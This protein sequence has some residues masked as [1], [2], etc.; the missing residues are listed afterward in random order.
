MALTKGYV[1][2]VA[3]LEGWWT[4]DFQNVVSVSPILD[5]LE[6]TTGI[7]SVILRSSTFH[8]LK[9]N[10]EVYKRIRGTGILYW[11]FHGVKGSIRLGGLKG[12]MIISLDE[13]ANLM[14]KRF[15]GWVCLFA[16][17]RLLNVDEQVILDFIS[18]TQVLMVVGYTV[19]AN[20][21]ESCCLEILLLD[22]LQRFKDMKK[23]MKSFIGEYKDLV[24]HTGMIVRHRP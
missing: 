9:H 22:W 11:A 4:L 20:F 12:D 3:C 18:K 21:L 17:C 10:V 7:G 19:Q 6:K 14:G 2:H 15:R 16:S 23:G 5:I 1:K 13:L 8:E 24:E